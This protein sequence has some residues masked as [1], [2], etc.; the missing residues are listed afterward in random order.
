[1][2]TFEAYDYKSFSDFVYVPRPATLRKTLSLYFIIQ[3]L[4]MSPVM[5]AREISDGKALAQ[6]FSDHLGATVSHLV[7]TDFD[8]NRI[9]KKQPSKTKK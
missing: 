1:M 2:F 6:Y 4:K 5:S 7:M 3:L 9:E 8:T